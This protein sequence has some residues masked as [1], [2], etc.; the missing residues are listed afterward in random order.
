[1]YRCSKMGFAVLSRNL[2]SLEPWRS[3]PSQL[4]STTDQTAGRSP[5]RSRVGEESPGSMTTRRRV[6]PAGGDPRDSATESKP[7]NRFGG[8]VR[9]KGW[10]KSP[11]RTGQPGRHGK[12]R[13]EQD[14]IG[15]SRGLRT[16]GR[17]WP[18]RPGR[19]REPF[20]DERSRGMIA[21]AAGA[22]RRRH[23]T[24]LTGRLVH[25]THPGWNQDAPTA[26][27]ANGSR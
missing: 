4:E 18:R 22:I 14:R 27:M 3:T 21:Y 9:V 20:G 11:P 25:F 26:M 2:A 7:P 12:P 19:S 23:R 15:A 1:M 24:R 8:R 17:R 5:L 13:L 10:G 16:A 6:T